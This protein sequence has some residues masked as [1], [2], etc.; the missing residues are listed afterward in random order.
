MLINKIELFELTLKKKLT[1]EQAHVKTTAL[2][3]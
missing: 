1:V 3:I 2:T